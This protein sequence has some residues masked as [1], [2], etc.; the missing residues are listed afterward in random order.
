MISSQPDAIAAWVEGLR[1]RD[2]NALLAV[3]LEQKRGPL[4]Y[5]L[6][7]Y[8]N[9]VLYPINPRTV[10]NYRKAFQPSR[11][12]SD[13]IDAQI[14]VEL[15]RQHQD[16]LPA[17]RPE[18]SQMRVLRQWVESRRMLVGEKVR[19]TNRLTSALKNYYP[20]V[21]DWFEDKDTQVC[22]DF[23]E[24]YPTL[25]AAQA[26]TPTELA[27]FFRNHRVIRRSAMARR[28]EQIA[29]SGIPLTEEPG[30]VEP[31]QWLGQTLIGQL[32]PLLV[33]LTELTLKIDECFQA[34]SDAA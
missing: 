16:K 14:L 27:Q 3:C 20:Q 21:L 7:Q 30:I 17:W 15:L 25:K 9:L 34:F 2:G 4:I 10:A 29:S 33:R 28:I 31:M 32:K 11:A 22:C 12:T 1:K 24:C 8:E 23:L 13:P 26:A 5:A 6:C 18:S 19:L